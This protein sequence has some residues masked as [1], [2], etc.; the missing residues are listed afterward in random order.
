MAVDDLAP[1]HRETIII[2]IIIKNKT[3]Q[4]KKKKTQ[5][6]YMHD[7]G[8]TDPSLPGKY[9]NIKDVVLPVLESHHKDKTVSRPS[10]LHNG[11]PYIVK[12]GLYIE[13]GP[14]MVFNDP[15]LYNAWELQKMQKHVYVS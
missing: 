11:N 4:K 8:S 7:M 14:R 1:L 10:Y 6:D 15:C 13:T 12:D 9:I 5:N 3:K 2:M